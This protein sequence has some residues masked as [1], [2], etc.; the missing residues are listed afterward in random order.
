MTT[1]ERGASPHPHIVGDFNPLSPNNGTAS[2]SSG[3][4][5]EKYDV[6]NA[7]AATAP[8]PKHMKEAPDGG[9]AAWLVVFGAWCTSF[10]SFGWINSQHILRISRR[11]DT[12]M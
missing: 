6:E 10:C 9:A 3:T 1:P 8:V 11:L 2:P 7:G 5:T 12:N 4:L